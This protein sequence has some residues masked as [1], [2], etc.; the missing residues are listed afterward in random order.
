M[1]FK[2]KGHTGFSHDQCEKYLQSKLSKT[3]SEGCLKT[4]KRMKTWARCTYL[5]HG[6]RICSFIQTVLILLDFL[7]KKDEDAN[8]INNSGI[9]INDFD[10]IR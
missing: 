2:A 8:G 6:Y 1:V 5:P 10:R 9:I 4:L 3:L 7:I